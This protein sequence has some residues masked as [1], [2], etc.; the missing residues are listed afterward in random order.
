MYY[1]S[2]VI[3]TAL[4]EVGYAE[5]ASNKDLDSKTAN[6]GSGNYTKYA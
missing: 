6:A 5:K 4:N 3:K 1:V 2:K